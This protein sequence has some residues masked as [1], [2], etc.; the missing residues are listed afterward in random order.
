MIQMREIQACVQYMY[1]S[2]RYVIGFM[3]NEGMLI[4]IWNN[5]LS[6]DYIPNTSYGIVNYKTGYYLMPFYKNEPIINTDMPVIFRNDETVVNYVNSVRNVI[7]TA[8][9]NILMQQTTPMY[10]DVY[11]RLSITGVIPIA[12]L[13]RT[14]RKES[15]VVKTEEDKPNFSAPSFSQNKIAKAVKQEEEEILNP[16]DPEDV[17]VNGAEDILRPFEG[18]AFNPENLSSDNNFIVIPRDA[19]PQFNRAVKVFNLISAAKGLPISK[20]RILALSKEFNS[21]LQIIHSRLCDIF[22]V[23][24]IDYTGRTNTGSNIGVLYC[25]YCGR[26][27]DRSKHIRGNRVSFTQ[28]HLKQYLKK[29]NEMELTPEIDD[30]IS[31][32]EDIYKHKVISSKASQL[33]DFMG[34]VTDY[35]PNEPS[36]GIWATKDD[37]DEDIYWVHPHIRLG[38]T[39]RFSCY[40]PN[41]QGKNPQVKSCITAP[42]GYNILSLDIS[43]QDVY[44]LVWGVMQDKTMKENVIKFGDP[45]KAL[46]AYCGYDTTNKNKKVL[47]RPLLSRMNGKPVKTILEESEYPEMNQ[48]INDALWKIESEKGYKNIVYKAADMSASRKPKRGG[49]FGTQKY[50]DTEGSNQSKISR[51]ILN[52]NFQ[53]TSAEILCLSYLTMMHDLL[54]NKIKGITIDDFCPLLPIHDEIV[55]ICKE[56]KV[57]VCTDLLKYYVLPQVEGWGRMSGDVTSGQHYE[58]K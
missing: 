24:T 58:H 8:W 10:I 48:M 27:V 29:F 26:L 7:L 11:N 16:W 3:T 33:K 12:E 23:H 34:I 25:N 28:E 47:K 51:Q 55:A 30:I 17:V 46:L 57:D 38:E 19:K 49:L 53:T 6:Q 44:V 13:R 35:Y 20:S 5:Y 21:Q 40:N 52:A 45:Y 15:V 37:S 36:S 32:T 22:G 50:I 43:A 31:V 1:N 54:N 2:E 18:E 41:P 42:K 9:G 39:N 56:D 4:D 14:P